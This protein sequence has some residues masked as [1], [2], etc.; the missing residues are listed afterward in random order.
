MR[1]NSIKCSGGGRRDIK[2]QLEGRALDV[3]RLLRIHIYAASTQIP[4]PM[5]GSRGVGVS[6]NVREH[7]N[8][9]YC[10]I[11]TPR[12]GSLVDLVIA[13]G[14]AGNFHGAVTFLREKLELEN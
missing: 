14:Y 3:L 5:C 4:C 7:Q 6:F 8:R 9:Y 11:C 13:L 12:G 2:V 10:T 1:S